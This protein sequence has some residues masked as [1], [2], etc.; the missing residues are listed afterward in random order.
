MKKS[1]FD[2]MMTYL[3]RRDHT[4][5]ELRDKLARYHEG[6]EIIAALEKAEEYNLLP[7][8]KVMSQKTSEALLRKGKGARYV[9]AY[10]KKK[11]L[12]PSGLKQEDELDRAR[13]LV[14]D[15][16]KFEIPFSLEEKK[17]IFRYLTN[18]GFSS[19][20]VRQVMNAK[21]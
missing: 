7:D 1:A 5:R 9:A 18:R 16:L 11:G 20:V 15:Q 6:D 19:Q 4:P 12:P 13:R 3:A 10:L 2:R 21:E 8:P 14:L 17:K